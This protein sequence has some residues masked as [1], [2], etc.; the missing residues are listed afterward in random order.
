MATVKLNRLGYEVEQAALWKQMQTTASVTTGDE[1]ILVLDLAKLSILSPLIKHILVTFHIPSS[2][3]H[4]LDVNII[5]PD[6]TSDNI[7]VLADILDGMEVPGVDVAQVKQIKDLVKVLGLKVGLLK[8]GEK[9][10]SVKSAK[11]K[12]SASDSQ[13]VVIEKIVKKQAVPSSPIE[14][15]QKESSCK[16]KTDL[17]TT[18]SKELTEAGSRTVQFRSTVDKSLRKK[19]ICKKVVRNES[20]FKGRAR[21]GKKERKIPTRITSCL[22]DIGFAY[23]KTFEIGARENRIVKEVDES[24]RKGVMA[25]HIVEDGCSNNNVDYRRGDYWCEYGDF[26]AHS[27]QH[28]AGDWYN[29]VSPNDLPPYGREYRDFRDERGFYG[30]TVGRLGEYQIYNN[31][32]RRREKRSWSRNGPDY[33]EPSNE[34][35]VNRDSRN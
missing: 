25:Q 13:E 6:F 18:L 33:Y 31:E 34:R 22:W 9:I 3:T 8:D 28:V 27:F 5:L 1:D 29:S 35:T 30:N 21:S 19:K 23:D 14:I 26:V 16:L 2:L 12:N 11:A 24:C 17:F 32:R 20:G 7:V 15:S 10:N 4:L